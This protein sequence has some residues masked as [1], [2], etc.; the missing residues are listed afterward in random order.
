MT[1]LALFLFGII[2]IIIILPILQG[3]S[4]LVFAWLDV[5]KLRLTE[6]NCISTEAIGFKIDDSEDYDEEEEEGLYSNT[7]IGFK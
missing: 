5:I 1:Y 2:F 4:D 6:E 3:I 7:K